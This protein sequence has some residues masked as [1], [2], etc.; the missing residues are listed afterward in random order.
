MKK[1]KFRKVIKW[2]DRKLSKSKSAIFGFLLGFVTAV[3]TM[4]WIL[5][6]IKS[7]II[8]CAFAGILFVVAVLIS[9]FSGTKKEVY[10]EKIK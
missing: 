1:E 10:W 5:F 3:I 9:F 7:N 4:L 8:Y 2:N 6:I